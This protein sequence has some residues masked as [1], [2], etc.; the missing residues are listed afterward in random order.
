ML[1]LL[2][3]CRQ[4]S[5]VTVESWR[6][7]GWVPLLGRLQSQ[8]LSFTDPT[9]GASCVLVSLLQNWLILSLISTT[10]ADERAMHGVHHD[11]HHQPLDG[12]VHVLHPWTILRSGI[13]CTVA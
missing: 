9:F 10:G 8:A 11:V 2:G 3:R 1:L 4:P 13:Y 12:D 5:S 6:G 7:S